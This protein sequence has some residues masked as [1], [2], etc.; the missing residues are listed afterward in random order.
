MACFMADYELFVIEI[1]RSYGQNE[2]RDDLKRLLIKAGCDAKPI[3]F[4]FSDNQ[5]KQESFMEDI[6]MLLNTGDVPNLYPSDEKAEILEK[7]QNAARLEVG[8]LSH[9]C[10]KK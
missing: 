6:S 2:W 9:F 5:I 10:H 4:L 1:T 7:M 8:I 3:V